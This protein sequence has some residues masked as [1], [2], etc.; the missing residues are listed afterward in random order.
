VS[1]GYIYITL[2][3][4]VTPEFG[5]IESVLAGI[6]VRLENVITRKISALSECGEQVFVTR[7]WIVAQLTERRGVSMQWWYGGAE[8]LYCRFNPDDL[9]GCWR[10]EFGLDGVD[11][12]R[13]EALVERLLG[14]FKE[15]CTRGDVRA[16]LV[17]RSGYLEETDWDAVIAGR[18]T[19]RNVPDI[20]VLPRGLAPPGLVTADDE[21]SE[22][23]QHIILRAR[24]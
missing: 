6:G 3:R 8:D 17:D 14:Y 22:C 23:R 24:Q 16:L 15:C 19:L 10:V 1:S 11:E 7:E 12:E 2:E 5:A 21:S 13:A 9:D 20:L 4:D 18:E